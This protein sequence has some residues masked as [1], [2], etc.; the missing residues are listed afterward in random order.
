VTGGIGREVSKAAT[1][2]QGAYTGESVPLHKT[3]LLGRF[4][5]SATGAAAVRAAFYENTRGANIAWNEVEGRAKIHEPFA[6]YLAEHP[7]ARFA[8]A[9][10]KIQK[11]L[12][13]LRKQK[14]RLLD[15]GASKEAIRLAEDRETG[16]MKRYNDLV[17]NAQKSPL[18]L[19][20]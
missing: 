18:N 4:V 9:G 2:I 14:Q 15:S 19:S 5:G 13:E 16:L 7:E 6:D 10:V 17:E 20:R 3:P 11:D 1:V 12:G 8:K